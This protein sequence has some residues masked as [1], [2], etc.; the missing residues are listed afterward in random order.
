MKKANSLLRGI[1]TLNQPPVL[2]NLSILSSSTACGG[3]CIP[4]RL[5]MKEQK[6]WGCLSHRRLEGGIIAI[7]HEK[8]CCKGIKPL[9]S[10]LDR[11]KW[12][13]RAVIAE[14]HR[15]VFPNAI[16]KAPSWGPIWAGLD[17]SSLEALGTG[18]SKYFSRTTQNF[19][20]DNAPSSQPYFS[21][22]SVT[23]QVSTAENQSPTCT[24]CI[25]LL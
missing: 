5:Q 19:R 23:S 18:W 8:G 20:S 16:D 4:F 6:A 25:L 14:Q 17:P 15:H 24:A 10:V 1:K 9:F 22:V 2:V 13:G 3:Y 7:K 11:R 21:A 12:R